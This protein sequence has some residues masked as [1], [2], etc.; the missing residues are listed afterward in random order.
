MVTVLQDTYLS[1]NLGAQVSYQAGQEL[2]FTLHFSA[3]EAGKYYIL[4]ALYTKELVYI[5]GSMFSI[6]V[7]EGVDYG[8]DSTSYAS[9]W[10]LLAGESVDLPCRLTSDLSDVVLGLFLFKMQGDVPSLDTD[11]QVA[12]VS[13]ELVS[14]VPAWGSVTQIAA[15]VLGLGMLGVV[16]HEASKEWA[17]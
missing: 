7:P 3:P 17:K 16:M 6:Y 10:E 15:M 8:T 12:S 14:P 9:V 5:P 13:A 4:G 2:Q 11:E 1:W